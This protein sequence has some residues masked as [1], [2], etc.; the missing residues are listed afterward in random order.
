MIKKIFFEIKDKLCEYILKIRFR[1][2]FKKHCKECRSNNMPIAK[3]DIKSKKA[4]LE[5]SD[6]SKTYIE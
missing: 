6:G 1:R 2:W 4:Y 5:Y 3:Y